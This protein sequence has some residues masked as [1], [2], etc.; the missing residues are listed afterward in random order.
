MAWTLTGCQGHWSV[1]GQRMV[2][3]P[4]D[5]ADMNTSLTPDVISNGRKWG[6]LVI[7]CLAVLLLAL[8][9]TV[10]FL[11]IPKLTEDLAPSSTQLLW[12]SD[13][14]GFALAGFLIIM[15]NIGDRIGRKRL[16][17]IGVV[18]FGVSSALTAFAWSPETLI[19]ARGLLGVAGAT[20]MPSTLSII[21]NVFTDPKQRT[22]AVGIWG[23]MAAGGFSLGPVV[24]GVL[25]NNFWWGSVFLINLPVMVV[26][27]VAA[28]IVLPESRNP[29]PGRLD[30]FSALLSFVGVV[31]V[32][33]A[34]KEGARQ[35]LGHTEV[36]VTGAGGLVLL[37]V[38]VVRQLQLTHPLLDV[39]LF[40]LPAFSASVGTVV[41]LMFAS[42]TLM[43]GIAQYLQFVVGWSPL[44]SGLAGMPG[45]AAGMVGGV[46]ASLLVQ[47]WGR[48]RVVAVGLILVGAGFAVFADAMSTTVNYPYLLVG[49]VVQGLGLGFALAITSDTMLATVPRERAGA[50]SAISETAQELGGA[51]GI[52]ILGS[53]L[54]TIYQNKLVLPAGVPAEA[55]G[56][57]RESLGGAVSTAGQ[58]GDV[59]PA[60]A[61][62]AKQAFV[63]GFQ[64]TSLVGA[65]LI[66]VMALVALIALRKVPKEIPDLEPAP[67]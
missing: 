64:T 20:I 33:Y 36:I 12:I 38:F 2:S 30:L 22:T 48:A 15:G 25:L 62:A 45:G 4:Q 3:A 54:T 37:V 14:Y 9:L 41:V 47:W 43:F 19:A 29:R 59:G 31:S 53:V 60:V 52:A 39:R 10:L 57:I 27:F 23:A 44:K 51:F 66:T 58:L 56:P 16:L 32:T 67:A 26:V 17:L 1:F 18:A 63:G 8:D 50:G 6:T 35:G 24:G 42:T 34:I 7:A 49:M 21:R 46:L 5:A 11:A 55:A 65:G 28:L 61:S 40:R 13:I